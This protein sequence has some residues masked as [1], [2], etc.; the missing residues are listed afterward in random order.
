MIRLHILTFH[1]Y[2]AFPLAIWLAVLSYAVVYRFLTGKSYAGIARMTVVMGIFFS[3]YPYLVGLEGLVQ[4]GVPLAKVYI[5]YVHFAINAA[6]LLTVMWAARLVNIN[7]LDA[8]SPGRP[9]TDDLFF[10]PVALAPFF[11]VYIYSYIGNL[12]MSFSWLAVYL[13]FIFAVKKPAVDKL[14]IAALNYLKRAV[15]SP[16]IL[17]ALFLLSFAIRAFFL[18]HL[19]HEVGV[20]NYV[21]ACDDGDAY[22]RM[23]LEGMKDIS[24]FA[25]ETPGSY[26]MFYSVFLTLVYKIFGHSFYIAGYLQ[27]LIASMM[28]LAIYFITQLLFKNRIISFMAALM[29]AIDQPLIHLTTTFNTEALYIP[30]LTFAVLFMV[31][32]KTVNSN[33][34]AFLYMIL[35]GVFMGL[36]VIIRELI[37]LLPVFLF[38]WI[39]KWGRDYQKNRTL[40]RL[41]DFG[42]LVSCM[43]MLILPI[44]VKNYLNTG[45]FHLVYRSGD[46]SWSLASNWGEEN[47]P[48]NASLIKLGVNPFSDIKGSLL[49]IA[50]KPVDFCGALCRLIPVR[51]RNLFLW[52]KFGYFDPAYMFNPYRIVN[53]YGAIMMFYYIIFLAASFILFAVSKADSGLKFLVSLP[54]IYYCLFHGVFFLLRSTRYAAPMTPFLC[55]ILAYGAVTVFKS[56][57]YW[58]N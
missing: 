45:K 17:V 52:P 57:C 32:Y 41:R 10:L 39:L 34:R 36:A 58:K 33:R 5:L 18:H 13:F 16:Y 51:I 24:Y 3:I 4:K 9:I 48:S 38:L 43:A 31:M 46:D 49:S 8:K 28:V 55:V 23:A 40:K 54:L 22:E 6:N 26:L 29:L 44:T 11:A 1:K 56:I 42:L 30:F 27:S 20:S 7:L 47:D 19:I 14:S 50:H 53:E 12:F 25:K 21:Y 37:V 2:I 35:G 15:K